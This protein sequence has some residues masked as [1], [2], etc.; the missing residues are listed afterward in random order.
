MSL[1]SLV[2]MRAFRLNAR[3]FADFPDRIG[4]RVAAV[5]IA[6]Q[7]LDVQYKMTT[8][9]RRIGGGNRHLAAELV[10]L[11]RLAFGDLFDFRRVR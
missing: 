11:V 5:G 3:P 8:G 4:E 7:G 1:I 9:R 2:N 10:G 6:M